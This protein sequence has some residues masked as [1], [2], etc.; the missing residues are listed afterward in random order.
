MMISYTVGGEPANIGSNL[1]GELGESRS[2][3]KNLT[4]QYSRMGRTSAT[5]TVDTY[6]IPHRVKSKTIKIGIHIFPA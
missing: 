5:E 4:E 2:S 1:G 6:S 3:M